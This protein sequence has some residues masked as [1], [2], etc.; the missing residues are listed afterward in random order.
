LVVF[1]VSLSLSARRIT[2]HA[3]THFD[4]GTTASGV[5]WFSLLHEIRARTVID[6][7]ADSSK[8]LC[9]RV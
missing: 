3:S 6:R 9:F 4:C 5:P 1:A 8:C 2:H 7:L